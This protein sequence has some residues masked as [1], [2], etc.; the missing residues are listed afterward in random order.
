MV[1][2][3]TKTIGPSG[4][5]ASFTAAEADVVNIATAAVKSEDLVANDGAIVF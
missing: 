4:D 5:Y 3:I 2:V 1:T